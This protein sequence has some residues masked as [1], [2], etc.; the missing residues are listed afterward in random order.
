[1]QNIIE[2]ETS[3]QNINWKNLFIIV[4]F[5]LLAIPAL[6]MNLSEVTDLASIGTLFAFV[7][8]CAG[9][10]FKDKEFGT[11]N[12]FVPYFN[13]QFVLPILVLIGLFL[14]IYFNGISS[15]NDKAKSN[16]LRISSKD[17]SEIEEDSKY[18]AF[19]LANLTNAAVY[20]EG[21]NVFPN[22]F[23]VE[24]ESESKKLEFV[25]PKK[26]KSITTSKEKVILV[27]PNGE[28]EILFTPD[29]A[30]AETDKKY[31]AGF[32]P[33]VT[34]EKT[35]TPNL[36]KVPPIDTKD[37]EN[38]VKAE[39]TVKL[40]QVKEPWLSAFTHKI[41][42]IAFLLLLGE[43]LWLS[44]L[45]RLSLIPVLGL[46]ACLYLMTELGVTNWMR[47]GIWMIVGLI[48]YFLY[49]RWNSNLNK[50]EA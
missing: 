11:E 44:W 17:L 2:L 29:K 43:L 23:T 33:F 26:R 16:E 5:H 15:L 24:T 40:E 42:M 13:S 18:S 8:V 37:G 4:S 20:S 50:Q 9:V 45:K 48:I 28:K 1:M 22:F 35:T 21:L 47:F 10:L 19:D 36:E 46:L 41:P 34:E 32:T 27:E 7:V 49:G 3:R 14:L 31:L 12:R 25:L 6:F 30:K 38:T 39:T